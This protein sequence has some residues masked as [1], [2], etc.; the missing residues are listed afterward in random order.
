MILKRHPEARWTGF[1][2]VMGMSGPIILGSISFTIMMFVDN[3][4]VARVSTQAFAAIGSAGLW[5]Y[6]SACF[7][8]GVVGCVGT[9]VAQSFGRGNLHDCARYAWQGLYV[10]TLAAVLA[11]VLLP[12]SG[13]LFNA[14]DHSPEVTALELT[15]FRIRLL[16]FVSIACVSALAAFFQSIGRPSVPMLVAIVANLCNV[17]LNYILIFGHFGMP[18]MGIAG[19]ATATVIAMALQV[20][21]LMAAFLSRPVHARFATRTASQLDFHKVSELLRIGLPVGLVMFMDV[22]NW[23]LFT[24]FI[25]GRFGDTALA[26]HNAAINFMHLAFMPALGLNQG[27]AAIVGQHIGRGN[28]DTAA[29]RTYTAMKIAAVYMFLMGIVL[30]TFGRP[31]IAACFSSNPDVLKLGHTLLIF[32]ALF[33][34]FDAINIIASGAL[35]GAGDTRWMAFVTLAFAYCFFL[36]TSLTLAFWFK[37][38]AIGAW[39][40][41]T[42]YIIGLSGFLFYRF[43]S[44][45]W[46]HIRIF[47]EDTAPSS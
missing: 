10:S 29:A 44:G 45:H 18:A 1:R 17:T 5:S 27:I 3:M 33:Q 34:A 26:S 13:P 25:V 32:A 46:R 12:V 14:M 24:S 22:A 36:P 30:A 39:V 8:L 47:S 6:I 28:F 35:R 21:L 23:G 15:Y 4:M 20:V 31:L 38:E 16:G 9:F 7:L 43:H 37:W 19:A 40:G 41:A 2:E 11:V 42:A